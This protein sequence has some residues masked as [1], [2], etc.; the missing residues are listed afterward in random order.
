M[1]TSSSS[2]ATFTGSS[3][4]SASLAQQ[5]SN[6]LNIASIPM[7]NLQ[8]QQTTLQ[9]Q[10]SELQTLSSDFS[11]LGNALTALDTATNSGSFSATTS[12]PLV[13]TA[14]ASS[15]ALAG[16]FSL[17]V[18]N[19]GANTNAMSN[20]TGLVKVT[21]PAV[22]NIST[23][24]DFTLWINS[25]SYDISNPTGSLDGLANAINSSGA[26]VQATVVNVGSSSSPDYRLSVQ[27]LDYAPDTVQLND[28]ANGNAALLTQLSGGAYVQYQVNGEASVNSTT[29]VLNPS[30]GLTINVAGVGTTTVTVAQNGN[31]ISNALSSLANA[32]NTAIA[33]LAKN[34]GQNGGAL[35]GDSTVYSL[36]ELLSNITNYTGTSGSISS[37]ADLGLTFDQN[38]NLNFDSSVFSQAASAN[39]TDVTNFL[40]SV[41]G[42]NGF[43]GTTNN[44]LTGINDP[45]TGIL[46][47][48]TQNVTTEITG[49]GNQ[50]TDDQ[51]KVTL[52]QQT[53][54]AQMAA[55]DAAIATLEQ[56]ASYLQM[57][58]QTQNANAQLGF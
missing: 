55:A 1:S 49:L 14:S 42:G 52:L 25:T 9:G 13:A 54:T 17:T 48:A 56:Q 36:T 19:I 6:S 23:S 28:T 51:A 50:I 20:D 30:P 41:A 27:S 5:I 33:E 11:S 7:Q 44:I 58:F 40:G 16:N 32:Y 31:G 2:P 46:T 45:S 53:L 39:L 15:G 4:F 10:Q 43:V 24:T 34:R 35:T 57:M 26:N 8:T 29:R 21:D 18:S 22:G 38:G 37:L 12:S 47:Q 3:A